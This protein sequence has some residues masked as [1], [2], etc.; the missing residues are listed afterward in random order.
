LSTNPAK[1]LSAIAGGRLDVVSD[2]LVGAVQ[3]YVDAVVNP[4]REKVMVQQAEIEA[5]K[6]ELRSR[7]KPQLK[8]MIDRNGHLV[9]TDGSDINDVGVVVGKDGEPGLGFDDLEI[10]QSGDR[11]ITFRMTRGQQTKEFSLFFPVQLYKEIFREGV[12]YFRGDTASL[13]GS[14]WYCRA[15]ATTSRPGE[16]SADWCLAVKRGRDGRD[17]KSAYEIAVEN[18]FQGTE[19]EW[20]KSLVSPPHPPGPHGKAK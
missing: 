6:A 7:P 12:T 19:K 13:G 16:G 14:I 3:R 11:T 4:L 2:D 1:Q 17:G 15:P 18:G 5:L 9:L 10:V 8:A 20:L